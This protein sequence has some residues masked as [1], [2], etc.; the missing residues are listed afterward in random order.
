MKIVETNLSGVLRIEPDIYGDSR[1]FFREVWNSE[2]YVEEGFP[3]VSFVQDNHSRSTRNVLRGLH[4]QKQ[5]PQG[6]LVQ[7]TNGC[8]VDIA[9]DIREDSANFGRWAAQELSDENG[10]QLWIPPGF[11]HGFCVL[12]ESA[13]VTYKCTELYDAASDSG[14]I[15]NDPQIGVDWPIDEP[16]LSAKDQ[17]LPTL[18]EAVRQ[19]SLPNMA[20]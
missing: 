1:G 6:K 10:F 12:S 19:G 8:V 5:R 9:V 13:D 20:P 14:I 17:N 3:H 15:W 16:L 2:R 4:F 11:A 18:S 7:V